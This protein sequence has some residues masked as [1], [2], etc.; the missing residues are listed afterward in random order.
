MADDK[1]TMMIGAGGQGQHNLHA[2]RAGTVTIR[3]LKT[4]PTNAQMTDMYNYQTSSSAYHGRNTFSLRDVVR[5]DSITGQQGAFRRFPSNSYAKTG[6]I[7]EWV[8][9]FV[10]LDQKIGTGTPEI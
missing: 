6:P 10:Q 5:G 4:S 7:M 1:N 2:G 8:F 9:D 3:L